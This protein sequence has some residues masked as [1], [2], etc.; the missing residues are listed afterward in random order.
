[1]QTNL[2]FIDEKLQKEYN[3]RGYFITPLLDDS[4]ISKLQDVFYSCLDVNKLPTVYDTVAEIPVEQVLQISKKINDICKGSFDL[5]VENYKIAASI[6]ISKKPGNDGFNGYHIDATMTHEKYNT[7]AIW[8]PLCDVDEKVGRMCLLENSH[9]FLP[10]YNIPSMPNA[11]KDVQSFASKHVKCFNMKKGEALFFEGSMLHGTEL[12]SS[13]SIRIA[14]VIKLIDIH[15]PK[16][17][18]YYHE[19]APEG[20]KLALYEHNDDFFLPQ[21]FKSSLPP[22]DSSFVGYV[23]SMP[24]IFTQSEI[25]HLLENR[26]TN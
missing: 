5:I 8:I 1:M 10:R 24:K 15:A 22:E 14:A 9:C 20:E 6:F 2:N 23:P 19:Q 7:V 16:I 18:A 11:Y 3:D 25:E 4:Q 26:C 21:A 17:T 13:E 12:N